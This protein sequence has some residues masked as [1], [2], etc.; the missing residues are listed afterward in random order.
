[1]C[2]AIGAILVSL[3]ATGCGY[4]LQTSQNSPLLKRGVHRVYVKALVNNTYKVGV[5]NLVYNQL[6]R[7]LSVGRRVELVSS[8]NSADAILE[9]KIDAASQTSS[10]TQSAVNIN[11]V[12]L[13]PSAGVPT[14]PVA[15][16]YMATLTCT[17]M[18]KQTAPV[19]D[20]KKTSTLWSSSFSRARPFPSSNQVG[21]LGTTS[22]LIND[23]EFDRA[24]E[25]L[26]RSMMDDVHESMLA[27]F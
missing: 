5:E 15:T 20:P 22:A 6:L 24:L 8:P 16:E 10:A 14:V 3:L 2:G 1:V 12:N 9:G 27:M 23:S 17:F 19:R 25:L 7:A 11:P 18:L 21:V 26:A 13:Y 4:T